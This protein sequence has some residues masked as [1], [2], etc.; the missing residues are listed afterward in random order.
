M[1]VC[2]DV[3]RQSAA[4][5]C[6]APQ[7]FTF[8]V[9]GNYKIAKILGFYVEKSASA[10]KSLRSGKHGPATFDASVFIACPG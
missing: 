2:K 4:G 10:Q 3:K 6:S 7:I 8:F 1:Q 9:G 5:I